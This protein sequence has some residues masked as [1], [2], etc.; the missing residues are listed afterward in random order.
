MNRFL[1]TLAYDDVLLVPQYSDIRSRSEIDLTTDLGKG[2]VLKMPIIASPMDTISEAEMAVAMH[3]AGGCAILHRYNTLKKQEKMLVKA[4]SIEP[5]ATI[6]V[7]I[8]VT[9]D[10]IERA[11]SAK[12]IGAKFICVDIAHGH[13]ILMKEALYTLRKQLGDDY[14]I[15]AGN[16]ATLNGINDLSDWGADSARANI[17]GG[18]ICSTRREAAAGIPGL[19]TLLEC[20]KTDRDITI[21]ADGGIKNSGDIVKALAAGADAI[22]CGSLIAGTIETPGDTFRDPNGFVWKDYRGMASKEAQNK[23]KGNYS[24]LEGISARVAAR[25]NVS[26][27]LVDVVRGIRSGLS[28]T[29][30]RNIAELQ[31]K[32]IFV[33]QTPSGLGE[34]QPHIRNIEKNQ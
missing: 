11:V 9:G 10:F 4:L 24:S 19:Q 15:M 1:T 16:V 2:V 18:A 32:A 20:S 21:I 31:N 28:Y 12:S 30:A 34:S 3:K 14:H 6:G 33:I 17:G 25:G 5:N 7:A 8:G 27:V 13:H 23:W 29:G 26:E 22:M